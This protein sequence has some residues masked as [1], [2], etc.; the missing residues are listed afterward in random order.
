MNLPWSYS[1]LTTSFVVNS[2]IRIPETEGK[3]NTLRN[4][5]LKLKFKS[6]KWTLKEYGI[7]KTEKR[8][9]TN[10]IQW[11]AFEFI[12]HR[13]LPHSE[14]II[15]KPSAFQLL[16]F[17]RVTR[18]FWNH[19]KPLTIYGLS[20]LITAL[21]KHWCLGKLQVYT[22]FTEKLWGFTSKILRKC[23]EFCTKL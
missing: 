14:I 4:I 8:T 9:G 19:I 2:A 20:V 11:D 12:L 17:V 21:V 5:F 16:Y 22:C 6:N 7:T 10:L 1:C 18:W 15:F 23:D 3:N 13:I